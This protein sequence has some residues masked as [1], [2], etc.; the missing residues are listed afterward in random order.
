MAPAPS[1]GA[2]YLILGSD[3]RAFV[4]NPQQAQQFGS[5]AQD[6]Q[7]NSDTMMVVHVEPNQKRT[8]IVSFPRDL[9]VNIPGQGMA[10]IELGLQCGAEQDHPDPASRLQHPDQP[11]HL[12]RLPELRV[13]GERHRDRARL[14]PVRGPRP[15]ERA[16]RAAGLHPAERR[17]GP[18]LRVLRTLQFFSTTQNAVDPRRPDRRH[19]ADRAPAAV[20]P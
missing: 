17:G 11:L 6:N 7:I 8:L 5:P 9:W 16:R 15:G 3:T 18:L 1:Q 10:K 20:H 4:T 13:G 14:L 19:R 2:N 12:G